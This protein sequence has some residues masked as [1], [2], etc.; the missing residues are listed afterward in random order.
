MSGECILVI[1]D[2]KEMVKHLTERVLPTFGYRTLHAFDGQTGQKLILE[3]EPDLVMLDYNLP[4]MTGLDILRWMARE[5]ISTPVV[6]MTGYGSELSAIEAFRLGAKDYLIKPF[7]IDEIVETIDHALVETR[8]L[9]DKQ[10]L[11]E[12]VRRVKVEMTRQSQEMETLFN[13]GK[14]ITSLLSVDKVLERVLKAATQLTDAENSMMWLPGEEELYVQGYNRQQPVDAESTAAQSYA[15]DELVRKVMEKGQPIRKSVFTGNGIHLRTGLY[16]RAA[17]YV[18]LKLRGLTMGVLG[19][20]NTADLRSFS[21]R[22]EFLLSFLADYAAIALE[23]A[24]VFQAADKALAAGL[25]ELNT[26]IDITRTITSSLDLDEVIRLTIK[27]VHDSWHIEASS[28]WLL[29][30]QTQHLAVLANVG[31]PNDI[32]SQFKIPVGKGFVGHVAHTGRW[33][34]SNDVENHTLHYR[35]VDTVT[36]FETRSILCVP[37]LSRGQVIGVLQLLNKLDGGFDDR[38]VERAITIGAAVAIAVTNALL[39]EEA[40]T[41]KRHLEVTLEHNDSPILITDEE[42]RLLLLNQ[43]ARSLFALSQDAVGKPVAELPQLAPLTGFLL[44]PTASTEDFEEDIVMADGTVW[45]PRMAAI[46]AHGRIVMLQDI[47]QL[48]QLDKAKD[49]F[50]AS[51][52][53]D[54][55]APLNSIIGFAGGLRSIG[56]LTQEQTTFIERIIH[57]AEQMRDMVD[58]LLELARVHSLEW[59]YTSCDLLQIVQEL[60][61]EFQGQA[62]ERQMTLVLTTSSEPIGLVEGEPNQLRRAVS[63]LIDNAL[64]YSVAGR[65]VE[66]RLTTETDGILVTVIDEGRGIAASDLPHIFEKFYRGRNSNGQG[67]VGLGLA[68]VYS[69]VAAHN[70]SVWVE[71]DEGEYGST[72]AVRLPFTQ[73]ER[74][75]L[76]Q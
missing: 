6:L 38:D 17:L 34:Y 48:R 65:K 56:P 3:G 35:Q 27:Q 11:A 43:Q 39:Y 26:L 50:V 44:K 36:G 73:P 20:T 23:N 58:G 60:V 1:D 15:E 67:G 49:H 9:H 4:E 18:P 19:V 59:S 28:L 46:P 30:E 63:N 68:V 29:N 57:G 31:T 2:S 25:D 14:A 54:M 13:I 16:A 72:F 75:T 74:V 42:E 71:S 55:R 62:L 76:D 66:V 10:E 69:I 45:L 7:T 52:S 40:E 51:V 5:S 24:R 21:R 8:L 70:G 12:Q 33:L 53:H 41:G 22:D 47:T 37:L 32:L 64:K 61:D